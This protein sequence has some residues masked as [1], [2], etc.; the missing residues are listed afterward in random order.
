[1][2]DIAI[3]NK[4]R[5]LMSLS[6]K[7]RLQTADCLDPHKTPLKKIARK[8]LAPPTIVWQEGLGAVNYLPRGFVSS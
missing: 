4:V 5:A 2:I 8:V 3:D 6:P 7:V 1:M